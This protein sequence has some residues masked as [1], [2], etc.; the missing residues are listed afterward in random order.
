[1]IL[2]SIESGTGPPLILL[3]GLFGA[4]KNLGV[5]ARALSNH[6]RVLS[7]DLRNH[8][9]SPHATGMDYG[10]MAADVAE[11]IAAKNITAAM[12]V[13]HSM[14]GKT[15]M[16]LALTQAT[17]VQK[18]VVMDIAPVTYNH[19]Y[20]GYVA[21]M[22]ALALIPSLTRQ[23]AGAAL[24]QAIP[25]PAM[26]A[27]L[28]N[29]LVL[30][31]APHWRIALPEIAAAMPDI[32]AWR[33]PPNAQ[34]YPGPTLFL[35]GATS[36]YVRDKAWQTILDKFPAAVQKTIANAGHWLHAE[37]PDQVIAALKEFCFNGHAF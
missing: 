12:V 21:A 13:G 35:R 18:L 26:R 6:A 15:A 5:I 32:L 22:Q 2:N 27:F 14:G 1:M 29:N 3:H 31:P 20:D 9:D 34:P 23:Q 8:G 7:L 10:R 28:L 30:G 11:T 25:E 37:Q 17:I 36:D 16:A 19:G 4:A 33:D 24:A